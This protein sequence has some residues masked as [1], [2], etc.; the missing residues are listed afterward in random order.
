MDTPR[1][2]W[3]RARRALIVKLLEE[4]PRW[5]D[6]KIAKAVAAN[7]RFG[8]CSHTFVNQVRHQEEKRNE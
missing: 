8:E 5:S 2:V 7:P 6:R 3:E 1:Q 4:H